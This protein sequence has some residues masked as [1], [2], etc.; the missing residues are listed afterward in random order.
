MGGLLLVET[1]P[2]D[3]DSSDGMTVVGIVVGTNLLFIV[4]ALLKGRIVLGI[5]GMLVPL[6]AFVAALRLARP[7][8]PWARRF[9]HPGSRRLARSQRR[10]PAGRRSRWDPLVDL[11]AGRPAAPAP[12][13]RADDA[14]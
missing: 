14:A 10:F 12:V 6:M 5:L 7:R 4:M 2:W 1:A 11:F 13:Q 8:S 9:Y 3:V